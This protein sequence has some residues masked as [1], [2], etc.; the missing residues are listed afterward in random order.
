LDIRDILDI[1][2]V[3]FLSVVQP[4]DF[5]FAILFSVSVVVGPRNS[6]APGL[7]KT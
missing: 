4:G 3:T 2:V 6:A 5:D 1:G 7:P